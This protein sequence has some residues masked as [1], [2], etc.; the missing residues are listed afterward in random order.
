MAASIIVGNPRNRPYGRGVNLGVTSSGGGG[1]SAPSGA[2]AIMRARASDPKWN[3]MG[4]KAYEDQY[5]KTGHGRTVTEAINDGGTVQAWAPSSGAGPG[6][7]GYRGSGHSEGYS[8]QNQGTGADKIR[9][10]G[11]LSPPRASLLND[12]YRNQPGQTMGA[13]DRL[14]SQKAMDETDPNSAFFA[15][16]AGVAQGQGNFSKAAFMRQMLQ[17]RLAMQQAGNMGTANGAGDVVGAA[18]GP[19]APEYHR[20]GEQRYDNAGNMW[21]WDEKAGRGVNL[22]GGITAADMMPEAEQPLA[23]PGGG[24]I[25]TPYGGADVT[26]QPIPT[27]FTN[28]HGSAGPGGV[29]FTGPRMGRQT[30][31]EFFGD[32]ADFTHEPNAYAA[33]SPGYDGRRAAY[34]FGQNKGGNSKAWG[35]YHAAMASKKKL[36]A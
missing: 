21:R 28:A 11:G 8:F 2:A 23:G 34:G 6:T 26:D 13:Y 10:W 22:G 4:P 27:T 20:P 9:E 35:A 24:S 36:A 1:P 15:D 12:L 31:E 7:K 19:V 33:P 3:M 16:Q 17:D 14:Q 32:R 18:S 30:A 29:Q 25:E 5:K